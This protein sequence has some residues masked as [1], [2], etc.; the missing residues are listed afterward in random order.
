M[1]FIDY[2]AEVHI[3]HTFDLEPLF[4]G[5]TD[6]DVKHEC[7]ITLIAKSGVGVKVT[8]KP[9]FIEQESESEDVP[10]ASV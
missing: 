1:S 9:I 7:T 6:D 3:D 10:E 8:G 4:N 5:G 2:I